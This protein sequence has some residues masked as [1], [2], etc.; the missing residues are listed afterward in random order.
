MNWILN[1]FWSQLVGLY[2]CSLECEAALF[3]TD[4]VVELVPDNLSDVRI[5]TEVGNVV[6]DILYRIDV[7]YS[8]KLHKM[9]SHMMSINPK[10]R[11][12]IQKLLASDLLQVAAV[13]LT[14]S[15]DVI[16]PFTSVA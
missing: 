6:Q 11:P 10:D 4:R 15:H 1:N 5:Q 7:F 13:D 3:F 9:I 12:E 16:L 14:N 2:T 8:D